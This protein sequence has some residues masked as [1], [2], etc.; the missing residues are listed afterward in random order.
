MVAEKEKYRATLRGLLDMKKREPYPT[1]ISERFRKFKSL[2]PACQGTIL[3][4]SI[5]PF[6]LSDRQNCLL[7]LMHF[8]SIQQRN[9]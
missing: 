2:P 9:S 8:V 5:I 6:N 7:V 4:S 1:R 3:M